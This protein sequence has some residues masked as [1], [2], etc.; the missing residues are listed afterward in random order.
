MYYSLLRPGGVPGATARGAAGGCSEA[1][2]WATAMQ[3]GMM[4]GGY[5]AMGAMGCDGVRLSGERDLHSHARR[6]ASLVCNVACVRD[7]G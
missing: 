6:K 3:G 5:E 4:D 2:K 7:S 1:I